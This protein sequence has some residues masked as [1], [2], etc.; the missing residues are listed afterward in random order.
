ML[1]Q[2]NQAFLEARGFDVELAERLGFADS[3]RSGFDIE[4]PTLRTGEVIARK[5][6][7][8]SGEKRFSQDEGGTCALWNRDILADDTLA[9]EPLIVTEGELDA[10]AAI[11]AGFARVVSVPNGAPASPLGETDS[12]KYAYLDEAPA[13]LWAPSTEIILAVDGDVP[14]IALRRDLELRLGRHRCK[15]LRYPQGCKD[16]AD[17][18]AKWGERGVVETIRRAEWCDVSGLYAMHELPPLNP[19]EALKSGMPGMDEHYRLRIGDFCVV[20]GV[21]GYGKTSYA[22]DLACRMASRHG[23]P[24]C[25]ASFEMTAQTHLRRLLRTWY[26]GKRVI[27]QSPEETDK[28]DGW[29][30][31]FFRFVVPAD[32]DEVTLAWLLERAGAAVVR[33]GAKLIVIDP[34]NELDH[35]RPPDMSL[36]EY[37]GAKLRQIRRFCRKYDVH[38]I[39]VAHPAKQRRGAD[40]KFPMPDLYDISDS[41]YFKNR[42]DVGVIVHRDGERTLI[43]VAKT[44]DHDE[45]GVPGEVALR[46][47]RERATYE[48]IV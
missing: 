43:R 22:I 7:T 35:D 42:C 37:T 15:W 30:R 38:L 40:G 24:C 3:S 4:I 13:A 25:I 41:A 47:A 29:I 16:L 23:W 17:A 33:H 27:E 26:C 31:Q 36:T 6:R 21:P 39:L 20:T 45:I 8:L 14:G 28:A 11:Q 44:R 5:Y 18:L 34:W 10:L 1:N 46:Y 2:R 12:R 19:P 32:D 9:K 48:E